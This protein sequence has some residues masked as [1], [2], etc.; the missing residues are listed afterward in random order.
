MGM[1]R[2]NLFTMLWAVLMGGA[3]ARALKGGS[4]RPS[5][6]R[7]SI[8]AIHCDPGQEVEYKFGSD[9]KVTHII[10]PQSSRRYVSEAT[11]TL[12]DILSASKL[13]D[14]GEI[15]MISIQEGLQEEFIGPN[16]MKA[17]KEERKRG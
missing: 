8:L 9:G 10:I 14:Y 16:W 17:L 15:A 12:P 5:G 6:E 1:L 2:R 13:H 7:I 4:R 3:A 11:F